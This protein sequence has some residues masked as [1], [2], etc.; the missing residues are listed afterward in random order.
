MEP[1][2]IIAGTGLAFWLLSRGK[3]KKQGPPRIVWDG[4][5]WGGPTEQWWGAAEPKLAALLIS[6]PA[7]VDPRVLAWAILQEDIPQSV[8]GL[9]SG[10]YA[11]DGS[12]WQ[13]EVP[14]TDN[15]WTGAPTVI[16]LMEHVAEAVNAALPHW[17]ATGEVVLTEEG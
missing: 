3:R 2:T 12:P 7:Q 4:D 16:F 10:P 6:D 13:T 17:Q 5:A 8:G 11:P 1:I 14:G 9:P 15:Y